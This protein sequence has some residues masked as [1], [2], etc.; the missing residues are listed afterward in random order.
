MRR[1]ASRAILRSLVSL[2]LASVLFFA[3]VHVLPGDPVRAMFGF[4]TPPPEEYARMRAHYGL[5]E[6]W[7][8]QFLKYQWNLLH[9]DFGLSLSGPPVAELLKEAAPASAK[10]VLVGLAMQLT[11]GIIAGVLG[12]LSRRSF[13]SSMVRVATVAMLS[14]PLLVMS[15]VGRGV[16]VYIL[17]DHRSW[18]PVPRLQVIIGTL[19]V[20]STHIAYVARLAQVEIQALERHPFVATATAMGHTR[21]R[22]VSH[23]ALKPSLPSILTLTAANISLFLT[24]LILVEEALNIDGLGAL[25]FASIRARDYSVIMGVLIVATVVSILA[26]LI[27]DL[28]GAALDPRTRT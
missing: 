20:A 4:R 8:V 10:L 21:W 6:P 1:Y 14:V 25:A 5:D 16:F 3:M 19:A 18:A 17:T 24:G 15:I 22:I 12:A 9:G 7:V 2:W 28:A 26:S 23:H 27:A 11:L 13:L